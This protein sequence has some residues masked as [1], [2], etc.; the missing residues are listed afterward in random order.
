MFGLFKKKESPKEY[1]FLSKDEASKISQDFVDS[2]KY[3]E[4]TLKLIKYIEDGISYN[5]SHGF[6]E[7]EYKEWDGCHYVKYNFN[8]GL[9]KKHFEE[10]GYSIYMRKGEVSS[11]GISYRIEISWE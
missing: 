2:G 11:Y 10:L 5:A 1:K 6:K 8:E 7:Y 9:L 3:D 4:G